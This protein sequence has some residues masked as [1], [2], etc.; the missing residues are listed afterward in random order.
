MLKAKVPIRVYDNNVKQGKPP[1]IIFD[2][3][4]DTPIRDKEKFER[5]INKAQENCR[6][7]KEELEAENLINKF[8]KFMNTKQKDSV[9]KSS[10]YVQV[11]KYKVN[12][13]EPLDSVYY[14]RVNGF[15]LGVSILS[16]L[17]KYI[18]QKYN[19]YRDFGSVYGTETDEE[20][21]RQI[22]WRDWAMDGKPTG[23]KDD[24]HFIAIQEELF[25]EVIEPLIPYW[26]EVKEMH[27]ARRAQNKSK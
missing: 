1:I 17:G 5:Y 23:I 13:D 8:Y 11:G 15:D 6:N 12:K 16:L 18:A 2:S 3:V 10:Q 9:M 27:A 22:A 14:T 25:G 21:Q 26:I 24:E 19:D 4:R 7:S 20:A